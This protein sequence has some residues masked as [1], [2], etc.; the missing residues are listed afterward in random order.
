M[1]NT[2]LM[3]LAALALPLSMGT[4]Y[5][6]KA[7]DPESLPKVECSALKFSAAFLERYPKAPAACLEARDNHGK[8][9]GKFE[10]KVYISDPE[11][12]TVSLLNAAGDA[13]TTFSFKPNPKAHVNVNGKDKKFHDMAVGDK[14]TFWISETRMTA[15]ALPSSTSES[16]AVLPPK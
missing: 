6:A 2:K 7:L 13:V 12:M 9:Y 15:E 1:N 5:A 8:R 3:L 11:F 4:V 16:W 10:A 14:L